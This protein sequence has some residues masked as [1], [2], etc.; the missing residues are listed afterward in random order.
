MKMTDT[1]TGCSA[2]SNFFMAAAISLCLWAGSA[3]AAPAGSPWGANYFPNISLINQ[4]GEKLRFYDDM[5]KDKIV[6]INFMYAT[7]HDACPLETAK[8]RQVQEALGDRVGKDIFMYSI[9][10][11]PEMDTPETL[12]T[13]MEKFNV[14]PGWQFLTGKEADIT[15]L[16]TKLGNV[17]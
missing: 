10:I 4:D 7:C 3:V 15:L 1:A 6:A 2:I 13:Y 8:L 16:R 9:S 11:T 12:K 14:G 5:I 17:G